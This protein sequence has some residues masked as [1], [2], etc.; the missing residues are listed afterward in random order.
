MKIAVINRYNNHNKVSIAFIKNF[1]LKNGATGST[2]V[3][4]PHNIIVLD[5]S[6]EY[7]CKTANLII[8]NNEGLCALNNKDTLMLNL[9]IAGLMNMLMPKAVALKYIQLNNF[10]RDV[11]NSNLDFPLMTLS[12]M[13]LTVV[14]T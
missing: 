10:C 3:H 9:P 7:L 8:E 6:Y 11:L 13:P 12:F 14:L 2:V 4:N 5:T 1:R